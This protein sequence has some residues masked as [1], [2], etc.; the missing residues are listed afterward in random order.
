MIPQIRENRCRVGSGHLVQRC[1][2]SDLGVGL[3]AFDPSCSWPERPAEKSPPVGAG[4]L[5]EDHGSHRAR[6]ANQLPFTTSMIA[7][8]FMTIW[9]S[10]KRWKLWTSSS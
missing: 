9:V 5:L 3:A 4:G 7:W 2:A 6:W 8:V 1:G 10:S